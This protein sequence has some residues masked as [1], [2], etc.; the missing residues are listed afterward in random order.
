MAQIAILII[1]GIIWVIVEICKGISSTATEIQQNKRFEEERKA[2]FGIREIDTS[3]SIFD[4]NLDIIENFAKK[5]EIDRFS[6]YHYR[7]RSHYR[8]N[9]IDNLI[10][11]CINEICLAENNPSILQ[12]YSYLSSWEK[13]VSN[14]WITLSSQIKNYFEHTKDELKKEIQIKKIKQFE[15]EKLHNEFINRIRREES[16][17]RMHFISRT[18]PNRIREVS[19]HEGNGDIFVEDT[20]HIL[21]PNLELWEKKELQIIENRYISEPFPIFTEST[22]TSEVKKL[23]EEISQYNTNIELEIIDHKRNSEFF[24]KVKNG[25]NQKNKNDVLTRVDYILNNIQFPN[26]LPKLW[27]SDYDPEQSILIIEL[28]LPDVVH[29]KVFKKVKLKNRTIEKP[30]TN[31]E[32]KEN[33]PKI[34]PAIILRIAYEIFRNDKSE[35]IK[36]LVLNGWVEYI[37]PATGLKIKTYTASLICNREQ[38]LDLNLTKID[39]VAAFINL[40]GKSAGTLIDIIPVTPTMSLNKKD[41]RFIETKEVLNNL[42]NE[43]NLAS[44]DWQDF[45]SLIAELFE[46][47]FEEKGA[48]VKVTQSSRDRG[49]DAIVFDPDP[50][51][52]GKFVIQAKRYTK[53]VDVSAVRDL[54]AV[55]KKEGAS[56][57]ILVTTSSYGS[58]SYTFAQNEPITLLNG[59][60]LL[61]LLEKHGYK[62][63]INIAEARKL[64]NENTSV[65]SKTFTP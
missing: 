16:N 9:P 54:C 13:T 36:L 1:L 43:T 48:E 33:I 5:I 18:Q 25:F 6:S 26:S 42:S 12:D 23:N 34:H 50:I 45:E 40:K 39:P 49:V 11:D 55:V 2:K 21:A 8:S 29:N 24:E 59:A 4:R 17:I 51:K 10:R 65:L 38:I 44:M 14:E 30:L 37:N 58:D 61:G 28:S 31:K 62:F 20:D 64:M 15:E 63:R 57:G 3:K 19:K 60:E 56:R 32:I 53:T 27:D 47:E 22:S 46:K 7:Y 41:K 52:G 35:T